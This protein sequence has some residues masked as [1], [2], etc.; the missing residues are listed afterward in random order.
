MTK[1]FSELLD[2]YC[3]RIELYLKEN[4]FEKKQDQLPV[5]WISYIKFVLDTPY[6]CIPNEVLKLLKRRKI[7]VSNR[8]IFKEKFHYFLYNQEKDKVLEALHWN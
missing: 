3:N 5:F 8:D 1:E 6:K 7:L 4:K 2:K